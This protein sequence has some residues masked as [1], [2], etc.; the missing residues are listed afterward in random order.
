[1][2]LTE[3][4]RR[5][6]SL[7]CLQIQEARDYENFTTSVRELSE[8]IERKEQRLADHPRPHLWGRNRP[9]RTLSAIVKKIVRPVHRLEPEKV[10]ISIP[11]AD[12]LF[13]EIR[14]ENMLMEANGDLVSLKNGVHVDVIF[15]AEREDTVKKMQ[16]S[17]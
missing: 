12:D 14:I 15:E 1:M 3:D 2:H 7:L 6:M 9:R 13:R 10:E 17:A 11:E 8:L 5:Q 16:H 4:E